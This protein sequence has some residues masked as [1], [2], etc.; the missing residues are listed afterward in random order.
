MYKFYA[1]VGIAL[2]MSTLITTFLYNVYI[3]VKDQKDW[4]EIHRKLDETYKM[5][6]EIKAI[7]LQ[8][9]NKRENENSLQRDC[10]ERK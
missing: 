10:A 6:Q 7:R 1:L 2:M 9:E 8:K 5:V 3:T 4:Q